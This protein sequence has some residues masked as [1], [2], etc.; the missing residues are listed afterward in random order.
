MFYYVY[1]PLCGPFNLTNKS[2]TWYKFYL[3]SEYK[4]LI[5]SAFIFFITQFIMCQFWYERISLWFTLLW[6]YV[7]NH[8]SALS[9]EN[10]SKNNNSSSWPVSAIFICVYSIKCTEAPQAVMENN[11]YEILK[12]LQFLSINSNNKSFDHTYPLISIFP[13]CQHVGKL[14]TFIT[15]I[16]IEISLLTKSGP[17]EGIYK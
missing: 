4:N 3:K 13:F 2:D 17:Q 16:E 14:T 7:F 11:R 6:N 8:T 10:V 15:E 12:I 1:I 9:W 5:L